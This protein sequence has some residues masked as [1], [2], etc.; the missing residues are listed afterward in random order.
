VT[1]IKELVPD[2]NEHQKLLKHLMVQPFQEVNSEL[3]K[4]I[5]Q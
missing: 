4:D 3:W 1:R 2:F 5:I